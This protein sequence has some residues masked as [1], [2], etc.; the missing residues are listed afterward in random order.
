MAVF[1]SSVNYTTK[2]SNFEGPLDLLLHLIKQ[3]EID[4]KDIFVSEVTSQFLDYVYSSDID[5]ETESEYL[6]IAATI[7]EI[8]SKMIIPNEEANIEAEDEGKVF[9][10]RLEE[11]K[12]YKESAEKLKELEDVNRFFKKPDDDAHDYKIV[13]TDFNVDALIKAFTNV[14]ARVDIKDTIENTRKE[15]PKEVFTVADKIYFIRDKLQERKEMSFY[16]LF[17]SYSTRNEIITTFQALLELLKM[18]Y[19][20]AEQDETYADIKIFLREDRSEEIGEID[21]YN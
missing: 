1:E 6:Q 9:I 12:L 15:I 11:Y 21:E 16:E 14:L 8:K 4:I 2:L 18:Q 13:Y 20:R 5:M 19:L 7:I 3:A 17:T 10:Q